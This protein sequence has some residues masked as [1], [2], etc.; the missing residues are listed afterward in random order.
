MPSLGADMEAGKLV[1]WLKKP[2]EAIAR[3]DIVAVV[4]T[5]KGAIDVEIFETGTLSRYLVEEGT[6]VPVGTPLA[7]IATEGEEAA[8]PVEAAKPPPAAQPVPAAMPAPTPQPTPPKIAP[9]GAAAR[10][11]ASPAARAYA[12]EHGIDLASVAPGK[13][14]ALRRADVEQA[15]VPKKAEG[16]RKTKPGLDLDKMR[17]AIAAAMTRSKREIPHYYLSKEINLRRATEWLADINAARPPEARLLMNIVLLKA[18]ARALKDHPKFNG[19]YDEDG[20]APSDGIHIGMAIAIRGGGLVAPALHDCDKRSLDD[21]MAALRDLVA[22]VRVGSIR[23]S[24]ISDPT[25]TVTSLGE[26]GADRVLGVIYPP[27]VAIVG[28]GAPRLAPFAH[29]DGA[30]AAEPIVAASLAADHRVTD[31]HLGAR[32]LAAIDAMLQEPE[33]L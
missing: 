14:E 5:E 27:Q 25:V 9:P 8:A 31:G 1:E 18:V 13:G 29:P 28:F 15:G 23:S 30:L 4:E 20:F 32:F 17:H 33:K 10:I 21:L 16:T 12:R 3:G 6:T 19:F 7:L 11:K 2:G 22:R 26:R 24:E